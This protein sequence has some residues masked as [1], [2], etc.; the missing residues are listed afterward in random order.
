MINELDIFNGSLYVAVHEMRFRNK[1][2]LTE[3]AI[4]ILCVH[5]FEIIAL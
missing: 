1:N 3:R 5:N 2:I 4:W